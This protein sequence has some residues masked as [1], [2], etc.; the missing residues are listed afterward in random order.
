[1]TI[2]QVR[3]QRI[4]VVH[5]MAIGQDETIGREDKPRATAAAVA[6]TPAPPASARRSLA[7]FYFHHCR[8]HA[9]GHAGNRA[10][11]GVEQV[12]IFMTRNWI[13]RRRGNLRL[14]GTGIYKSQLRLHG[15]LLG[16]GFRSKVLD[17]SRVSSP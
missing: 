4:C 13:L 12:V 8:T 17:A 7:R 15:L 16:F 10:R 2:G 3:F 14:A 5:Y 1:M 11:V 6:E 9:I